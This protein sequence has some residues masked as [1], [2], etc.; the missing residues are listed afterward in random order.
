MLIVLFLLYCPVP[1]HCPTPYEPLNVRCIYI[2]HY[3]IPIRKQTELF[4]INIS[5]G[6]G[7][8]TGLGGFSGWI[9]GPCRKSPHPPGG[10]I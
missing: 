3:D 5:T 10:H 4:I 1:R 7:T 9:S 2:V 6:E 8:P